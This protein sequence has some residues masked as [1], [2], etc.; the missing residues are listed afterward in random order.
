MSDTPFAL[1]YPQLARWIA[2]NGWIEIGQDDYSRSLVRILDIGGMI[3]EGGE[4]AASL[5]AALQA[6][7]AALTTF[8]RERG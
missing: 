2:D 5:D 3:W 6:A 4:D 7:E 8:L 1:A